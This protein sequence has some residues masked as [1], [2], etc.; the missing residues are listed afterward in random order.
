MAQAGLLPA[1]LLPQPAE[2]LGLQECSS[3]YYSLGLGPLATILLSLGAA[4]AAE[5]C[6]YLQPISL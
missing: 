4:A 3:C 6:G 2:V 1:I 5:A